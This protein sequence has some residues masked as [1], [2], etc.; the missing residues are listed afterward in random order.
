MIRRGLFAVVLIGAAFG[1][2]AAI[3]GPGLAWLQR[4][5][6]AGRSI[7]VDATSTHEPEGK[8]KLKQFPTAN[9]MT[10]LVSP[11][12]PSKAAP[13]KKVS[14][15]IA[16]L[17]QADPPLLPEAPFRIKPRTRDASTARLRHSPGI[18]RAPRS[19]AIVLAFGWLSRLG[20]DPEEDEGSGGRP[21]HH[22]RRGRWPRPVLLRDP[23]RRLESRRPPLRSRGRRRIPGRRS[24]PQASR[25]LESNQLAGLRTRRTEDSGLRTRRTEDSGL[26][27]Q[28]SGLEGL[29]TRKHSSIRRV[30]SSL[31]RAPP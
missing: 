22:R 23:R 5:F 20:D 13:T 7:I 4:N 10:I 12:R 18:A 1:G 19:I 3:N 29:R 8:T 30:V 15:P 31:G 27:T 21:I 14:E 16:E 11:P 6:A 25:H 2:G 9:T 26:R 24:R 17:A 28:D